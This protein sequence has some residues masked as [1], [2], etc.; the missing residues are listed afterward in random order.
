MLAFPDT[1]IRACAAFEKDVAGHN[2]RS[3]AVLLQAVK[4][5]WR[6]LTRSDWPWEG[7]ELR[8]FA[9][10]S[11]FC[12]PDATDVTLLTTCSRKPSEFTSAKPASVL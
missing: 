3:A 12:A 2:H 9:R 8:S 10:P 6:K 1:V 4:T 7:A 11:F 5:S